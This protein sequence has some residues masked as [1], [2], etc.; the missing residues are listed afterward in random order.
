MTSRRKFRQVASGANAL[1][2][3]FRRALKDGLTRDGWLAI[4]GPHLI[5]EAVRPGSRGEIRSVLVAE[6]GAGKLRALIE[7][8]PPETEIAEVP[9]AIFRQIARTETPQGI[10]ALAEFPPAD[11]ESIAA[12]RNALLLVACGVQDPGNM[13]TM[14]RS[15]QALGATGLVTLKGTVSPFNPKAVRASAGAIFHLPVH[16]ALEADEVFAK[17]RKRGVRLLAAERESPSSASD[18][19][20][21]GAVALLIGRE[22]SGLEPAIAKRADVFLSI[23]LRPG[24]DS[25]NAS[26][27]AGIF[28][29]E[30]A[31][32]RNFSFGANG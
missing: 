12:E 1:V 10:A 2:K 31:K 25:L 27:A 7:R 14:L 15:A 28:L 21:R 16:A 6:G 20:L 18:F 4:E 30:A 23:P 17:L 26:V 11:L 13:G 22:G 8:L 32:Q 19:D 29:Y 5:E 9:A 24:S 3:V